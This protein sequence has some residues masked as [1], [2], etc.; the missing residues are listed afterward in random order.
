MLIY[1]ISS[2]RRHGYYLFHCSFCAFTE[3]ESEGVGRGQGLF[4]NSLKSL[5]T[6]AISHPIGPLC[7]CASV[8]SNFNIVH[9]QLCIETD[10]TKWSTR[11]DK[12]V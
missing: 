2:I 8:Y 7:T 10:Y 6:C 5:A 9:T 11:Y 4:T 1:V 3:S 12:L